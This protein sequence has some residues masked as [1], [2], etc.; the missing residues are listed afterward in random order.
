MREPLW[1]PSPERVGSTRIARLGGDLGLG[2]YQALHAWSVE[3]KE[4]F[5]RDVWDR[6]GVLGSPGEVVLDD[7]AAMPGARWF[8]RGSLNFAENLLRYRD[9]RTALVSILENGERREVSYAELYRQAVSLAG[10]LRQRGVEPGDRVAAFMPNT[11]E[12]VVAMLAATSIGAV[13]SSCSPDF[14]IQGVLD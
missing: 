9:D 3:N 8:P 11:V 2:D 12:T 7:P 4:A 5:W 6:C 14:G 10:W 13:F 1:A